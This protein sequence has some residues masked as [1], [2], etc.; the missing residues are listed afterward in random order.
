MREK[1]NSR[2]SLNAERKNEKINDERILEDV[3]PKS[4]QGCSR[5]QHL[6]ATLR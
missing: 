5:S 4:I 6:N 2:D 1:A 3:G